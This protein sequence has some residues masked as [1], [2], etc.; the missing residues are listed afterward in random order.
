[1]GAN[2]VVLKRDRHACTGPLNAVRNWG[3]VVSRSGGPLCA[4]VL[5]E[6]GKLCKAIPIC[7]VAMGLEEQGSLCLRDGGDTGN[8]SKPFC[9]RRA[10]ST[11]FCPRRATS[12][13]FCPRRATSTSFCP[14]RAAENLFTPFDP[15]RGAKGREEGQG[16]LQEGQLQKV[17]G[18]CYF[19]FPRWAAENLFT[20]F[21]PRRGAKG[22]EEGQ[23]QLQEGQ[24][25]KVNGD[26]CFF[27]P[28]RATKKVK[29]NFKFLCPRRGAKGR[30]EGQGQL[31]VRQL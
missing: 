5:L 19:F 30:K 22:R 8:F 7:W 10:T 26:F 27:C 28:R 25:Q 9:P 18:D 16:Q 15:R 12:T 20:P 3:T 21:D 31:Q 13:S 2:R 14:R 23:G 6:V 29:G 17:N 24:L 4:S 11:S 1:M